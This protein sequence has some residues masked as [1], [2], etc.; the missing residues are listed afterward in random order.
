MI[1][2]WCKVHTQA[3]NYSRKVLQSCMYILEA[4]KTDESPSPTSKF[5]RKRDMNHEKSDWWSYLFKT[6]IELLRRVA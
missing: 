3:C 4:P 1:C 5:R 2:I 6:V